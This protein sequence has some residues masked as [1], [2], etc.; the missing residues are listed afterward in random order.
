LHEKFKTNR[1]AKKHSSK[2]ERD[3]AHWLIKEREKLSAQ[4]RSMEIACDLI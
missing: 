1:F 4:V 3:R 2:K